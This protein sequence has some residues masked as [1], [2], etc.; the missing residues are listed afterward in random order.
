MQASGTQVPMATELAKAIV[1]AAE[2]TRSTIPRTRRWRLT[3]RAYSIATP[4]HPNSVTRSVEYSLGKAADGRTVGRLD[5]VNGVAE[6]V[7]RGIFEMTSAVQQWFVEDV[8]VAFENGLDAESCC[9]WQWKLHTKLCGAE[10]Q[11]FESMVR[12]RAAVRHRPQ[13]SVHN[14][15]CMY[16]G[17]G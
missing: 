14:H 10:G 11:M 1:T 12:D 7:E 15:R 2:Q 17:D 4:Q 3:I 5:S 9:W 16:A 8:K 6:T 13:I